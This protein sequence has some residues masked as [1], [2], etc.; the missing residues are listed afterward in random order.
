M[1]DATA[2]GLT[3]ASLSS[4]H[5]FPFVPPLQLAHQGRVKAPYEQKGRIPGSSG[6]HLRIPS[7]RLR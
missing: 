3:P 4:T 6:S 1:C 5:P 7:N 2:M